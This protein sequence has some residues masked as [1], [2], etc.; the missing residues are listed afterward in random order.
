MGDFHM[1]LVAGVAVTATQ[2]SSISTVNKDK[3]CEISLALSNK[4][5]KYRA[6]R[7]AAQIVADIISKER[8]HN[9]YLSPM[10]MWI[11]CRMSVFNKRFYLRIDI[12][13]RHEK[14]L[15]RGGD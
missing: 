10:K 8:Q 15:A 14:T 5:R 12:L 11:P 3:K 1:R 9:R 7:M 4:D 2:A 6:D 13:V